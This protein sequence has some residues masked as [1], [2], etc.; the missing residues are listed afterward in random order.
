MLDIPATVEG[1]GVGQLYRQSQGDVKEAE[2]CL[3]E[4]LLTADLCVFSH[5]SCCVRE[6][7][8]VCVCVGSGGV[9][10]CM[11]LGALGRARAGEGTRKE[12][13]LS[14]HCMNE[15]SVQ[16]IF[17]RPWLHSSPW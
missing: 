7:A 15:Q 14:L 2:S 5:L 4:A 16:L 1:I 3:S 6:G 10:V 11:P 17:L 9:A 8:C 13:P 12:L